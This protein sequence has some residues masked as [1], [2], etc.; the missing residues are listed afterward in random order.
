MV[1]VNGCRMNG[2]IDGW[3]DE[4]DGCLYGMDWMVA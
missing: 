4:M 3:L 1:F 2:R